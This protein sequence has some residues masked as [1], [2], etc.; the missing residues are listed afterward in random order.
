MDHDFL[1][2]LPLRRTMPS[3][4]H[5]SASPDLDQL[6]QSVLTS[7]KY[8]RVIRDLV[9]TI[10]V[11]E[12][13]KRRNLK[14]AVKAT[15]NKLHQIA[16]AY[17]ASKMEY[18]AWLDRLQRQTAEGQTVRPLCAEIMAHHASTRERLPILDHFYPTLLADLPPITSILDL[19]CGLNP[20]TLPWM[21]LA[22]PVAYYACDIYQDQIDFLNG[23][24][25]TIGVPGTAF[26]CDLLQACPTQAVDV[27]LLLKAIPCL[28][29]ADKQIGRRL[30][31]A[32]QAPILLVS[33]PAQ[34]LG[35]RDKGMAANYE[36]HFRELVAERP[37]QIERFDFASELVFRV[38]K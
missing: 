7:S 10:G 32:I 36:F 21:P 16:G 23:F 1:N 17:L 18:A 22:Q 37:W 9:Y 38:R 11:Q 24:F 5:N 19:A 34:S 13:T 31:D 14:E 2:R 15:K 12:L 28:E 27:A 30:L 8:Q 4:T 26:A 33:F 35:G 25:T 29:Q 20:L 6:V 3:S